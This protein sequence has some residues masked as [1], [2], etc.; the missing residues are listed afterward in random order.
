MEFVY[1]EQRL[2]TFKRSSTILLRKIGLEPKYFDASFV[3]SL[4][5]K[6]IIIIKIPTMNNKGK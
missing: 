3:P 4:K 1:L 2:Y 5:G 6:K